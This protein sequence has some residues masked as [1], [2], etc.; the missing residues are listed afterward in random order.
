MSHIKITCISLQLR[1]LDNDTTKLA[2]CSCSNGSVAFVFIALP[3]R[4]LAI[5]VHA[6]TCL[7]TRVAVV[8]CIMK[9]VALAVGYVEVSWPVVLDMAPRR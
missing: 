2:I 7:S 1:E 6:M 5:T 8:T 4:G 9:L 3:T